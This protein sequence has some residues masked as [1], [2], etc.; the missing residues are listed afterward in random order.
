[1]I[2]NTKKMKTGELGGRMPIVDRVEL[3]N[4]MMNDSRM[5]MVDV[6]I[7]DP[8]NMGVKPYVVMDFF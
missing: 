8:K 2:A 7:D 6:L 3:S 1:M 5:C 4:I